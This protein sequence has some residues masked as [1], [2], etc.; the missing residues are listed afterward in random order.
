M[1]YTHVQ[2]RVIASCTTAFSFLLTCW[3]YGSLQI[4][5][6]S[7]YKCK[8]VV[9]DLHR[10]FVAEK[11]SSYSAHLGVKPPFPKYG[12][13]IL[14]KKNVRFFFTVLEHFFLSL[15]LNSK[16]NSK[17][18]STR[19]FSAAYGQTISRNLLF[20]TTFSYKAADSSLF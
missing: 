17:F 12:S 8:N 1:Y 5:I 19:T 9:N 15:L 4:S 6:Y 7:I 13:P 3:Y 20:R 16:A 2:L 11:K 14:S 10:A 18:Y